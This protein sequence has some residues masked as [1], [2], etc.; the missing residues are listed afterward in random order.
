MGLDECL[1]FGFKFG[2]VVDNDGPYKVFS[3]TVVTVY[4]VVARVNN[5]SSTCNRNIRL[6]FQYMIHCLTN[7]GYFPLYSA[8][9]AKILTKCLVF[10]WSGRAEQFNIV[11]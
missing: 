3:Q 4:K 7:N 6:Y 5:L 11:N 8:T 10:L 2:E 1:D 9:E